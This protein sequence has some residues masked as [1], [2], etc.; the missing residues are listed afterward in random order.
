MATIEKEEV[1]KGI[2]KIANDLRGSVDGWDF[3]QYVLGMLFYRYLSENLTQYL[4]DFEGD[5]F[6]YAELSD[7]DITEEIKEEIINVKGFFIYPSELFENIVKTINNKENEENLNEIIQNIFNKIELSAYGADSE[8]DIKS[9]LSD[10]DVN[11]N[12]LGTTIKNRCENLKKLIIGID[13]MNLKSY[14][15]NSIDTFGDAYEY[16]I[17]M[18]ASNAGKSGGEFYTPQEVSKLLAKICIGNKTKI[19]KV[20]DP[21]CGSG[22]LLLQFPKLLGKENILEGI[23]GQE[24]NTTTYNLCRM[25]MFLHNI[26]YSKFNIKNGDT[27]EENMHKIDKPFD[28]IVSNPPYSVKWKGDSEPTLINDPRFSPAGILAPKSKAD[29]A[30]IMHIISMLSNDG[31]AAVV[32]FPGIL[33]RGGAE[34]KIRKYLVENN[35]VDSIIQLPEN[36]FYGTS[37][38]TCIMTLKKSKTDDKVLF[39]DASK[40]FIKATNNNKLTDENI[41]NILDIF[42]NRKEIDF[43]ST[44][45]SKDE[46]AKEKYN[47]SVSTYVE[48]EDTTEKIDIDILNKELKEIVEKENILRAN[49]DKIIAEI[50]GEINE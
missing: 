14:N 25:N 31:I 8:D 4:N 35:F 47:L 2:W 33:Y 26:N 3:K 5:N 1:Y 27:L 40:E 22:S 19:R 10:I 9:I 16:L 21:T 17:S 41:N 18:Y 43:K 13:S 7:S 23:Y 29:L 44:L 42:E 38:S 34:A 11:S 6:N 50:E 36:L 12:K 48:P 32:C 30:F 15:S 24:K 49:I 45:I 28:V 20:Y 39:V 46:I 37:I